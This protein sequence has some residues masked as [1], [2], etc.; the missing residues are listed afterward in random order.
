MGVSEI[1]DF[2]EKMGFKIMFFD[3][4][5]GLIDFIKEEWLGKLE[6]PLGWYASS[7]HC[8]NGNC[9]ANL[10]KVVFRPKEAMEVYIPSG[11]TVDRIHGF[12]DW[13]EGLFRIG[14]RLFFDQSKAKEV[15]NDWFGV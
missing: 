15:L 3:E 2:L 9:V 4:D 13:S 14:A 6:G 5:K 12:V 10:N 1:K 7:I 8:A 11:V